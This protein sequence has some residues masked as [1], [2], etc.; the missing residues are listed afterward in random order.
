MTEEEQKGTNEKPVSLHPL[1][2][3]DALKKAMDAG[4]PDEKDDQGKVKPKTSK[5]SG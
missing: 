2:L 1:S 5:K 3:Y 4:K